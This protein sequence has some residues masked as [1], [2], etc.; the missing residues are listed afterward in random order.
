[1]PKIVVVQRLFNRMGALRMK[2]G[3]GSSSA[4]PIRPRAVYSIPEYGEFWGLSKN[5]SYAAA[6]SGVWP[7]VW[8]NRRGYIPKVPG[9]ALLARGTSSEAAE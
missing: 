7:V 9:D 5:G 6:K 8:I 4:R 3:T 2:S 1:M